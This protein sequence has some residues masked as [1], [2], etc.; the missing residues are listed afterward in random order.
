MKVK[1]LKKVLES[2]S[3]D[4]EVILAGYDYKTGGTIL[5]KT[6]QCC[7][8][9]HQETLNEVWLSLEGLSV[10]TEGGKSNEQ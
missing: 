6:H 4:A 8:V 7:N 3:D 5:K 10:K 2:C 1:E 9:E